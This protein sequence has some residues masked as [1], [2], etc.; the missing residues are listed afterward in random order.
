[1]YCS[2]FNLSSA[3]PAIHSEQNPAVRLKF[4]SHACALF[5]MADS[6]YVF[7]FSGY[8]AG[9]PTEDVDTRMT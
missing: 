7:V 6:P 3:T 1:M 4:V 8:G 2:F 5:N 9:F